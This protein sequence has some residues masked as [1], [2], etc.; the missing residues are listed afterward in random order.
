MLELLSGIRD[1]FRS[2]VPIADFG[3]RLLHSFFGGHYYPQG[4][5]NGSGKQ[6]ETEEAGEVHEVRR[7]S[8]APAPSPL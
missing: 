2:F 8:V 1:L 7:V 3:V 4:A 5:L 6:E